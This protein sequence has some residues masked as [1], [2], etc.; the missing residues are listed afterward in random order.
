M[1]TAAERPSIAGEG[2]TEAGSAA[3]KTR[4]SP[5]VSRVAGGVAVAILFALI[6]AYALSM[7]AG[8]MEYTMSGDAA[9]PQDGMAAGAAAPSGGD[10]MVMPDGSAMD[11]GQHASDSQATAATKADPAAAA[12][13]EADHQMEMGGAINWYIIGGILALVAAGI[14]LAAG[15]KEHLARRTVM[16]TLVTGEVCS[17]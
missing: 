14:A 16:G 10:Q 8:G 13:V 6:F 2:L 3:N 12:P 9:V 15:L 17:E 4:W 7:N 1:G 11:M 5:R